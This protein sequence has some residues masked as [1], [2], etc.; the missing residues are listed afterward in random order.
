MTKPLLVVDV[1]PLWETEFTGI[2]NVVYELTKRLLVGD[3]RFDI[4][5]SVFHRLLDHGVIERSVRERSG[6]TLRAPFEDL[7]SL[8]MAEEFAAQYDGPTV[9]LFLHVKPDSGRFDYEAQL[10]YDFSYL[11]VPETHHQDTIDYHVKGLED[12][13]QSNDCIFTI[14]ASVKN[15]LGFYF[16]YP[17]ERTTVALL[18]YHVDAP[19]TWEFAGRFGDKKVEPYFV[20]IGTIEPRKNVRLILTWLARNPEMLGSYRFLFVGR[21]AWGER[22]DELIAELGLREAFE[23]GRIVHV[24]YVNEA[25]KTALALGAKGLIYASLFEGF[26]L[27][28]LEAMALGVP[29]VASCSTSIPEVV[30]PD[31]IM[32][33]PLS[34][35]SF[36]DAM[37]GL[38]DEVESGQAVHRTR[39]LQARAREFSYDKTYAVIMNRLHELVTSAAPPG[40][41]A[42]N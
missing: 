15:D 4:R 8:T 19:T 26:G 24:G 35:N 37:R 40:G 3:Q 12:Q 25:Q 21:D 28:V 36:D 34:L 32:F 29:L 11:S 22:L 5:F 38:I 2:A 20:C 27:P 1:T 17:A 39:Q 13:V 33:D 31:G 18:G 23:A 14:S 7:G 16:D 42:E 41:R 6:H 30:G 9:R 10:Y